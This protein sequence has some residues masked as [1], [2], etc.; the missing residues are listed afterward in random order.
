MKIPE[1]FATGQE[2]DTQ[3]I[4]EHGQARFQEL[5]M[6]VSSNPDWTVVS[7]ALNIPGSIKTNQL[8]QD[9]FQNGVKRFENSLIA[10][11]LTFKCQLQDDLSST[12]PERSYLI[13]GNPLLIKSHTSHF[14]GSNPSANLFNLDVLALLN[15]EIRTLPREAVKAPAR[16][17]LICD[18]PAKFCQA[19]QRH[20]IEE[21]QTQADRLIQLK[22]EADR[23]GQMAQQVG[24]L[25]TQ[26]LLEEVA[27]WPKPGLVDPL[28]HLSHP[29]MDQ[30]TFIKSA[31]SLQDYFTKCAFVGLTT[32][33]DNHQ[34]V[35]DEIRQFGL[36]AEQEMNLATAGVNTHKGAIFTLG[37]IA[38]AAGIIINH[39]QWSLDQLKLTI[40]QMLAKLMHDDLQS[41]KEP[42][43]ATAG[44]QQY[45]QYGLGGVREEAALGYPTVFNY[46][47]PAYQAAADQSSNDRGVTTLLAIARHTMDSNLIKRAGSMDILQERDHWIDEIDAA[48]GITTDL[49]R[50]KLNEMAVEFAR[51]RLSMGGSAD[52]LSATLF[53]AMIDNL[54][55]KM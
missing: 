1:I 51:R 54:Q 55:K 44:Q 21:L 19:Q 15:G 3:A 29:D 5:S 32:H 37:I 38:T 35:F 30:F 18:K 46:G 26:A 16:R 34:L 36:V 52:L 17:C 11:G 48:G 10:R 23:Q 2:V 4:R 13:K 53:I 33:E 9:F 49:G 12:G 39:D 20:S 40:Q 22:L 28:E 8:I 6:L 47:L 41:Q 45:H 50:Q 7:V 14:E 25:A 27:I 42:T 24:K 31:L 43:E